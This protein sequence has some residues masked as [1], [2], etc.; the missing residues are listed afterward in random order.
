MILAKKRLNSLA[1]NAGIRGYTK[2]TAKEI[3]KELA[4]LGLPMKESTGSAE[5]I[6]KSRITKGN[7]NRLAKKYNISGYTKM[8]FSDLEERLREMYR[9]EGRTLEEALGEE[10]DLP[11]LKKNM[12][13]TDKFDN[14]S[15][16]QKE[17]IKEKRKI[18]LQV[19][20]KGIELKI[21]IN[22]NKLKK[23]YRKE[24]KNQLL[25]SIR[26]MLSETNEGVL[27][28][29][30][31]DRV[32]IPFTIFRDEIKFH[33]PT[34]LDEVDYDS[35]RVASLPFTNYSKNILN[36]GDYFFYKVPTSDLG[37]ISS[38]DV[39]NSKYIDKLP[40]DSFLRGAYI[41]LSKKLGE[42]KQLK[43]IRD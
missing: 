20:D 26:D 4:K 28:I 27:K 24:D 33:I 5:I 21:K 8:T 39:M 30:L 22:G 16:V 40:S 14:T 11:P 32:V 41:E 2:M 34:K 9:S 31:S 12:V 18:I 15:I 10:S 6:R 42:T 25:D 7:L 23:R 35:M 43:S 38:M 37:L 29:F 1:K 13:R 3:E 17:F 36:A 19:V